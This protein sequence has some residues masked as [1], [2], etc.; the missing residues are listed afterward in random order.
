MHIPDGYLSPQTFGPL[1]AVMIPIWMTAS[2][3]V[4]RALRSRQAPLLALGAAFSFVVMMFNIPVPGGTSG[5]AVGGALVAIL[6]GPWAAC[7]SVSLALVIQALIFGDG[8]ITAL[9]ANAFTMAVIMP[10]V[11]YYSYR[12]IAGKSPISSPRRVAAGFAAGYLAL[13]AAAL[14]AAILFGIQPLIAS[15]PDGHPLYAPYPLAVTVPAMAFPHLLLFGVVEGVATALLVRYL[16]KADPAL[17]T[18]G[19]ERYDASGGTVRKLRFGVG[20]LALLSPLGVILPWLGGSGAGWGEW[21][22]AELGR[23]VGY[24]PAGLQRLG[25]LWR[26]PFADYAFA[27]LDKGGVVLASLAYLTS[28][29]VGVTALLVCTRICGRFLAVRGEK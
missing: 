15:A 1:Y 9:G 11:G 29:A 7:V 20:V 10:F 25:E 22:A 4:R 21:D 12:L 23:L 19:V 3:K 6:L 24:V 16:Q 26:A 17:L 27:G 13:N 5:H 2:R 14:Y 8:G 28:A 18:L